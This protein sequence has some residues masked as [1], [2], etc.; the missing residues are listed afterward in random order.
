MENLT[1][2][3]TGATK[4]AKKLEA[5]K[6]EYPGRNYVVTL[7][8]DEFTS[9]CPITGQPDFANI[10]L[11]YIPNQQ[12]LESKSFK[13]YLWSYRNE[14]IFYEA[15]I[16]KILD[17]IVQILEPHYCQVVGEFKARGGVLI[18]VEAVFPDASIEKMTESA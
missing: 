3:G 4:P 18:K 12:I 15:L 5:F 13:L 2:L 14:G 11:R 8:T 6:N 1:L 16:N 10:I 7:T 9:L 17:D